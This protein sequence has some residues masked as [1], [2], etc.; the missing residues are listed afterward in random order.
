MILPWLVALAVAAALTLAAR[1]AGEAPS[2]WLP[3]S[4]A[5]PPAKSR[6]KISP[7]NDRLLAAALADLPSPT[8]VVA[9]GSTAFDAAAGGRRPD[10]LGAP[11]WAYY[12]TFASVDPAG[13]KRWGGS[14]CA[15]FLAYWMARSN[16]GAD[17][18]WPAAMIDRAPDDA[19]GAPG[20]GFQPGAS[21]SKVVGGA[22][23]A[24]IYVAADSTGFELRPG[25]AYHQDHPP[26]ANSDHVGVVQSVGP[27]RGDGTREVQ[28]ID[29]GQAAKV[30]VPGAD[31]AA[32]ATLSR[33]ASARWQVR[34]LSADGRTLSL[35]GVPARLLGVARG[36]PNVLA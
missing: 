36:A 34:V 3:A 18:G 31:A 28:T 27:P 1:R 10:Y 7:M 32:N 16:V 14:T 4:P 15:T 25:D 26:A 22:K 33:G 21:L 29:G 13:N 20:S 35:G 24:G 30:V 6:R 12:A 8:S 23:A 5:T 19:Y 17:G 9:P 2:P 11:A